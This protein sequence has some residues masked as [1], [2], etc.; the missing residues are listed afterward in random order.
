[1]HAP[2]AS[3]AQRAAAIVDLDQ[4]TSSLIRAAVKLL[5]KEA[6]PKAGGPWLAVTCPEL[7]PLRSV[8]PAPIGDDLIGDGRPIVRITTYEVD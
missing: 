7:A 8:R 1:M 2:R 6:G 4:L 5:G 3:H